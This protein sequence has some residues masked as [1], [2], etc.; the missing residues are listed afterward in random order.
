MNEHT[1]SIKVI[2]NNEL[3]QLIFSFIP[4]VEVLSP[5]WFRE[6]IKQKIEDNLKKYLAMQK[7]CTNE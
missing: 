6:E 3:R 2:P 1:I 4:D 5:A 7:G